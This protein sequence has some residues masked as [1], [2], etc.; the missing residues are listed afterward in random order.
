MR[1]RLATIADL[2]GIM[3][4]ERESFGEVGED[5]MASTE[6]MRER[7]ILSNGNGGEWFF[8]AEHEGAIQAYISLQPT[9]LHPDDCISWEEATDNGTFRRTFD[10][11]G[12]TVFAASLG[13]L[14]AAL[15]GS[16]EMLILSTAITWVKHG[17]KRLMF[18]SRLPGLDDAC[19]KKGLT[20]ET[21]WCACDKKG[22]PADPLL[23]M[24]YQLF[25]VGPRKFLPNG[26]MPDLESRGHAALV[27]V[28]D[29]YFSLNALPAK[30][31]AAGFQSHAFGKNQ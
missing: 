18:C 3:R 31:F 10:P 23:K 6:L 7:I 26:F 20:P 13:A 5:A 9:A 2:D 12:E 25:N 21:Y 19:K 1:S 28:E 24:F 15:S 30:I 8:V 17:K 29:P 22:Q 14:T 4:V 16:V 27:V 11:N